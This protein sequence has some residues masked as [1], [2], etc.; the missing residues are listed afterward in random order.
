[1]EDSSESTRVRPPYSWVGNTMHIYNLVSKNNFLMYSFQEWFYSVFVVWMC[2]VLDNPD[3]V[4]VTKWDV[5]PHHMFY[6]NPPHFS[7]TRVHLTCSKNAN[8]CLFLVN[9]AWI[10]LNRWF[11]KILKKSA[12][13]NG[14]GICLEKRKWLILS[15][16]WPE[17]SLFVVAFPNW[18]YKSSA[19]PHR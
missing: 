6:A 2:C 16:N 11:Y 5:E 9:N 13:C 17:S 3:V 19:R 14:K 1:M 7:T 8:N 10:I 15:L 12:Q 4:M 18:M